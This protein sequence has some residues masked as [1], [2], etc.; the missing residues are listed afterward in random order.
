MAPLVNHLITLIAFS[1]FLFFS[2]LEV[3]GM[4]SYTAHISEPRL[5]VTPSCTDTAAH[6][7]LQCGC[8]LTLLTTRQCWGLHWILAPNVDLRYRCIIALYDA[9]LF[10]R[11]NVMSAW[12]SSC[13]RVPGINLRVRFMECLRCPSLIFSHCLQWRAGPAYIS[14]G[15]IL[16]PT[17]A[18]THHPDLQKQAI[19]CTL[20]GSQRHY[21]AHTRY[22]SCQ[23]LSVCAA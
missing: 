17:Q 19:G 15:D 12:G 9:Y 20:P 4:L 23:R 18:H 5:S 16:S 13:S 21:S 1:C 8:T 10:S 14:Q 6:K 22:S 11:S 2:K 7:G 3:L